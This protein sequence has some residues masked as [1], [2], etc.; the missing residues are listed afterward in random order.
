MKT[1]IKE[2][3]LHIGNFK[4]QVFLNEKM[5][6]RGSHKKVHAFADKMAAENPKADYKAGPNPFL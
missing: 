3:T 5:A 2:I 6:M 4:S 1:E